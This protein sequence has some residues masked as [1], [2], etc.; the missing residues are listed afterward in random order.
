MQ[1][2]VLLPLLFFSLCSFYCTIKELLLVSRFSSRVSLCFQINIKC[3]WAQYL[4]VKYDIGCVQL[5]L[6]YCFREDIKRIRKYS[7][8]EYV[9]ALTRFHYRDIDRHRAELQKNKRPRFPK[10]NQHCKKRK[11]KF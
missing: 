3:P 9:K 1:L 2:L 11:I 8:S 10:K 4:S 7:E 6:V 5:L